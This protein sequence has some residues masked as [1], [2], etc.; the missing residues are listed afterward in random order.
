[1]LELRALLT[2]KKRITVAGKEATDRKR[3]DQFE[4]RLVLKLNGYDAQ[5]A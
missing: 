3:L 2:G 4:K 1:M 5:N